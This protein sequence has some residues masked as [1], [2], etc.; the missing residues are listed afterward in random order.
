[1]SMEW[2]AHETEI[3]DSVFF[4]P[5]KLKVFFHDKEV[6]HFFTVSDISKRLGSSQS[7]TYRL[8][9]ALMKYGFLVENPGTV[10]CGLGQKVL[11][12]GL[13]SDNSTFQ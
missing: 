12:L 3:C 1:M 13:L 2:M 4:L 8:V 6:F 7:K 5:M 10:Q 9:R 11:R